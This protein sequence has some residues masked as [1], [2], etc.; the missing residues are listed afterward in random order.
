ML[1]KNA[2]K[3]GENVKIVGLGMDDGIDALKKRVAEKKMG[4]S[5]PLSIERRI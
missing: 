3:W 2:E 4:Q 5:N 1:T